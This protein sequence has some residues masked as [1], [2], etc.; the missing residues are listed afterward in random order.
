M[1]RKALELR[2]AWTLALLGGVLA[3]AL[4]VLLG[5]EVGGALRARAELEAERMAIDVPRL[6]FDV[7]RLTQDHRGLSATVLAGQTAAEGTRQERKAELDQVMGLFGEQLRPAHADDMTRADWAQINAQWQG[8]AQ[9][10]QQRSI[11][12][13]ESGQR[14][15]TLIEAELDVHDRLE[16]LPARRS[17]RAAAAVYRQAPRLLQALTAAPGDAIDPAA[18]LALP[19]WRRAVVALMN[20]QPPA[21]VQGLFAQAESALAQHAAGAGSR[22]DLTAA[23]DPARVGQAVQ[24]IQLALG[25]TESWQRGL[26]A[27]EQARVQRRLLQA[28]AGALVLLGLWLAV[29]ARAL[30]SARA[31]GLRHQAA[32]PVVDPSSAQSP[33]ALGE[34]LLQALRLRTRRP[35]VKA[36]APA[37]RQSTPAAEVTAEGPDSPPR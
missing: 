18:A 23:R 15:G 2:H 6:L 10:V 37:A 5:F 24:A 25:S 32:A 11:S 21:R 36:A 20:T 35:T 9:A 22:H 17:A 27:R 26:L 8:L 34:R 28:G 13:A 3:S 1:T 29:T 14:H 33:A 4:G 30:H 31:R 12:V 16:D 7:V 19:R